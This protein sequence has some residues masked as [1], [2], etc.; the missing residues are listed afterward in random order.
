MHSLQLQ[1]LKAGKE[2]WGGREEE[3]ESGVRTSID[4]RIDVSGVSA[5]AFKLSLN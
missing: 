4:I 3:T 2:R 5:F 1:Q